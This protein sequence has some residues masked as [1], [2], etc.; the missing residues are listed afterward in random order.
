MFRKQLIKI[1]VPKFANEVLIFAGLVLQK[2]VP[3]TP[4]IYFTQ[5]LFWSTVKPK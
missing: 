5:F 4:C 2:F 3:S 1:F